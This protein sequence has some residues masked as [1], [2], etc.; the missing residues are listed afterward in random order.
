MRG[1][2]TTRRLSPG[3]RDGVE[4]E[5]TEEDGIRRLIRSQLQELP[6]RRQHRLSI[7]SRA[8]GAAGVKGTAGRGIATA[9]ATGIAGAA[10]AENRLRRH[11]RTEKSD[12]SRSFFL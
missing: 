12:E 2:N 7:P 5:I 6:R 11:R 9:G 8:M 3:E 1:R 10:G 4:A